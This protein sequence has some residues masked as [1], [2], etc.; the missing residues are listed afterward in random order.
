M[1]ITGRSL[2]Q[3]M[4][5]IVAQGQPE[6]RPSRARRALAAL[7]VLPIIAL[8]G[9]STGLDNGAPRQ[10]LQG[11]GMP[12]EIIAAP[13][14]EELEK[15]YPAQA[16]EKGIDGLVQITVTVDTA[17]RATDTQVISEQPAGLGF[18]AAASE[19]AHHFKYANTGNQPA[20][21]TYK[22]RF[23]LPHEPAGAADLG[24]P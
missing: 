16:K 17:G 23:A 13:P 5:R 20:Y 6:A 7:S 11:D 14:L 4:E 21:V 8:A 19:L 22:I 10:A 24:S 12:A 9:E 15:Y 1:G 18:A 2:E 3:R